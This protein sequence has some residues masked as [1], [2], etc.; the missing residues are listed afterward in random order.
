[1]LCIV[2]P[3]L[4]AVSVYHIDVP[5]GA[6]TLKGVRNIQWDLQMMEFNGVSPLPGELRSMLGQAVTGQAV[7][8]QR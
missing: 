3:R 8:V 5:T 7:T 4:R 1:M 6:I 2:D